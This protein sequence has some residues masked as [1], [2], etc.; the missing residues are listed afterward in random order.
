MVGLRTVIVD[1]EPLAVERLQILCAAEPDVNLVGT[2]GDGAAALRLAQT[3]TPDLILLDIGM[4]KMDG[5]SVA[6]AIALMERKPAII[7]VTAYDNFAVE[8]FDLDVVD[9]MLKPV[10]AD[11][12]NRAIARAKQQIQNVPD[13]E[14]EG[15]DISPQPDATGGYASEFW[16][17]HRSE[18]IRIAALDIERI[19]A[20]RDYM[21]LHT[22]GR[23]YLLH[24]TIST[25]E[26]RLDPSKFQRI[27]RSH[28]VRHDL[29]IGLRHEGG[30]VWHALLANGDSMRI[31]RKYLSDVKK[32]AGK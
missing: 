28:I 30:G 20:E 3:L 17:S 8:A 7:F 19:E 2:A 26:Q 13:S 25:L 15:G 18:L 23:S 24:Q 11:R 4:P 9:Y 12:L 6:R 21:R 1:D 10:S 27:H 31:G 14:D 22:G 29:I 32:L 5:I 16:V